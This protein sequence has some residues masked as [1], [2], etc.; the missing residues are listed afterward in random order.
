MAAIQT[1]I[2]LE[3]RVTGSLFHMIDSLTMGTAA[4]GNL[5]QIFDSSLSMT[6]MEAARESCLRIQQTI[7]DT[8][9]NVQDNTEQQKKLN[10]EIDE[11]AKRSEKLKNA[12]DKVTQVFRKMKVLPKT[13]EWIEDCTEAYD[14]QLG[15]Q[16]QLAGALASR[17]DTVYI[18]GYQMESPADTSAGMAAY[19]QITA[20][21]GE[22]QGQGIYSDE[23]MIGAATE[24]TTYFSD[25]DA[26]SMMMDNLADYAMGMTGGGRVNSAEMAAFA[27]DLG[28]TM[29]GDYSAMSAAGFEFS[30]EQKA[31]IQGEATREQIV[32]ALG[33][34]Y[35]DMSSDMQ[36][37]AAIAQVVGESWS[38]IY[39]SMSNTPEGKILQLTNAWNGMKE[40]I[41]GQLYPYLLLFVGVITENWG[42]IQTV[43]D[44][45]TVVLEF[46]LGFISLL[47][48]GAMYFA[49]MIM[50]N[51]GWISP[52]LYGVIAALAVYNGTMVLAW[53]STLKSAAAMAWKT[54][55]D[56]VE[57]GA[58]IALI[59]AQDGLNAA[60]AACPISWIII[61]VIALIAA[62]YAVIG[63]IN[64]LTGASV[65]A[66]GVIAGTFALLIAHIVN[67]VVVPLWNYF[68]ALAN[69]LGNVFTNPVA[70]V[71][72][73][74][75]DMCLNVLDYIR[76]MAGA[77]EGL[78]NKI[79]GVEIDITSGLDGFYSKLEEAQKAVKDKSGWVEYIQKM[80]YKDYG[81]A[82]DKGYSF[83]QG[84]E[85]SISDFDPA[86][87]FGGGLPGID[88]YLNLD[89]NGNG[90]GGDGSGLEDPGGGLDGIGTNVDDI[91]GN[92]GT[93]AESMELSGEDLQYLRDIAEQEAINRF[94]TAEIRIE[95]TNHN[96]INSGMDLDGV[97]S[98]LDDALGEAIE[99]M[100]EG[101]H[102]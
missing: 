85:E 25:T 53:L 68:A 18:A 26:I 33:D 31:I 34:E 95:Q 52:I 42:T 10:D 37:A 40:S 62:F 66:T 86:S 22:I 80:D 14:R 6:S 60:L 21:A 7:E 24:L 9:Q 71:K 45:I 54:A 92:T 99:I 76:N 101:V 74:F 50:D 70:A 30:E 59:V 98:G 56:L 15:V 29:S 36:A 17:A 102:A 84:M 8:G 79:P 49:Q 28:K 5:H 93:M 96:Q 32:S 69:F 3:D 39:E 67:T 13:K 75:Y 94:T 47:A 11:G 64:K 77:I 88:E 63:V 87:L 81:A 65:S 97:V 100:T 20:K 48:E 58:I 35:L 78:L 38:G 12:A 44:G 46:M 91:A 82:W 19:D 61:L 55:C 27:A 72:V 73:L 4:V 43:L 83:G 16:L 57:I 90:F 51:W 41:G 23:V 89:Q 1:T 2:E